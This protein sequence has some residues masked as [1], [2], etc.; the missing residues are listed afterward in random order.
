MIPRRDSEF[1]KTVPV[2]GIF[3]GGGSTRM[4]RPKG[5]LAG[6][7]G[8]TLVA[9]ASAVLAEVGAEVVLV[10]RR[11]EYE[12]LDMVVLD[13]A[14]EDGGPL[15]G[16]VSLLEHAGGRRALVL[17]CDMPFVTSDDL[18]ALLRAEGA[19]AAPR[20]D[21]R[22]EGLCAAYAPT[23]LA[24][25]RRRLEEGRRSMQGLLREIGATEVALDPAHL[26][27]WD[28]PEDMSDS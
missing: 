27:D 28:S 19:I 11:A 10:G 15:A 5:L 25:A 14:V 20:R 16:L 21:D 8:R 23:V 18:R 7:D 24:A 12:S 17:A 13:D 9:R 26:V 6:P 22:W 4:G 2:G 1:P 3:V